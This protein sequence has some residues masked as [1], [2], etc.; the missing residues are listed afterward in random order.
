LKRDTKEGTA[1][2]RRPLRGYGYPIGEK[3]QG[4]NT[5]CLFSDIQSSKVSQYLWEGKRK[6]MKIVL[7]DAEE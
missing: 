7:E 2:D 5:E 4:K 6:G 1:G 3:N